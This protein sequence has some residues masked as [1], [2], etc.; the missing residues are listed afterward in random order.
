[1]VSGAAQFWHGQAG[2]RRPSQAVVHQCR[3]PNV[4]KASNLLTW[5]RRL[6][7]SRELQSWS[8]E[9]G[10]GKQT[11]VTAC[12]RSVRWCCLAAMCM[13][14]RPSDEEDGIWRAVHS[15]LKSEPRTSEYAEQTLNSGKFLIDVVKIATRYSIVFFW[16]LYCCNANMLHGLF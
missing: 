8:N 7:L 9:D 4:L 6:S 5:P 2:S 15:H 12:R 11:T 14:L 1:M 16:K 13:S 10:P 3:R